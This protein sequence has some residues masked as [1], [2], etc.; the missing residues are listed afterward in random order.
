PCHTYGTT[1]SEHLVS[2]GWSFFGIEVWRID[3]PLGTPTLTNTANPSLASYDYQLEDAAQLGSTQLIETN[4]DR[5]LDAEY[6]DGSIWCTHSIDVNN[7][8]AVRWY[9]LNASVGTITQQGTITDSS[10][11]Y[12]FPSIAVNAAGDVALGFSGSSS[13]EYASAFYTAREAGDAPGTTQPVS[14]MKAGEAPYYKTYSGTRNRWGDYSATCVD[15]AHDM[16][17]WT[18]QEYA[19]TPGGGYDRW[20]TW[21]GSFVVTA[22]T[23]IVVRDFRAKGR[24]RAVVLN[25]H[26]PLSPRLAGFNVL[27]ADSENGPFV[28]LNSQMLASDRLHYSFADTFVPPGVLHYYTLQEVWPDGRVREHGPVSASAEPVSILG[29]FDLLRP[30]APWP[31]ADAQDWPPEL[32]ARPVYP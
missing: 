11:Y 24:P 10:R 1:T 3:D 29:A 7:R 28:P 31:G 21:W 9:E 6:R 32:N 22:P 26:A 19:W 20:S 12:Y 5:M 17:F 4:D 25:W 27:R 15:P 2:I 23:A 8:T 13:T 30:L 18:L 14:L 16:T